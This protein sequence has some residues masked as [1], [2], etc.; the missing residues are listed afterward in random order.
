V[1]DVQLPKKTNEEERVLWEK[2]SSISTF[3]PRSES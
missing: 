1:V 2:L 3:K